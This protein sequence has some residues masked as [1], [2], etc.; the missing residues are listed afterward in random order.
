MKY[1]LIRCTLEQ[2]DYQETL[3]RSYNDAQQALKD[4]IYEEKEEL[5]PLS[6]WTV[7]LEDED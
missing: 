1:Q 7:E 2:G 3:I 6:W 4:K 5:N